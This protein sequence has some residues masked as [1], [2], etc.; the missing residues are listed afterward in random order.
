MKRIIL[1]IALVAFT[2]FASV[3]QEKK[4][5]NSVEELP[6]HAYTFPV[7]QV[8]EMLSNQT[9]L[10]QLMIEIKRDL[11]NDLNAYDIQDHATLRQYYNTLNIIAFLEKDYDQCLVYIDQVR[12][13]S[14][15]KAQQ[16]LSGLF[17]RQLAESMKKNPDADPEM[18]QA[19]VKSQMIKAME[20]M[21]IGIIQSDLEERKGEADLYSEN[22]LKGIVQGQ[23][24]PMVENNK[25]VVPLDVASAIPNIYFFMN[26]YL[27]FKDAL[28]GAYSYILDTYG[29]KVEKQNIWAD[30]NL[31]LSDQDPISPVVVGIWDTG[32]DLDV[33]PEANRWKNKNEIINGK[34]DD[35]NGFV[36]DYYGIAYE[37]KGET[38][39]SILLPD[40]ADQGNMDEM[41]TNMKGLLDLTAN[42]NSDEATAL[43][44]KIAQM[45]AG[46]VD[47]FIQQIGLYSNFAHGTHVGGIAAEGNP[48][49]KILSARISFD[50]R[51]VPFVPD[52]ESAQAWANMFGQ[53]VD[54]FKANGVKVV[55]M[56]WT[57]GLETEFLNPMRINGF[58]SNEEERMAQA[59]KLFEIERAAYIKAVESAPDI[60]FVCG[61]GNSNN[62]VD[63]AMEFP[64][65]L[66]LPNILTV[67]AVDIEGKKTG[68]TT[69]GASVDV[70]ANGYEVESLV[71]GGH[72]LAFSGTSMA[73][74]QVVN[75][76]AK[77]WAVDPDLTVEQ[78]KDLILN[79][80]TESDEHIMLLN[81]AGAYKELIEM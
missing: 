69:E 36:D 5:I 44:K 56:S 18:L 52:E 49:I 51:S 20:G 65:S 55:N 76:A 80:A 78:V 37:M 38:S 27:P 57:V 28:V 7:M 53:V 6:K 11:L 59:K 13:N 15:K 14:D 3:A 43:K 34:D 10:T 79:T 47:G 75:L 63:F 23:L 30:R 73:S 46:D 29:T 31:V 2:A 16:L 35:N 22:V 39:T 77:L 58:G 26:Y 33:F 42:I 60:L 61:A 12:A 4:A 70:Y 17:M 67:G 24:Q 32:V 41:E 48:A 50:Y 81:P 62:D 66:N 19:D 74:P 54:Y 1:F 45:P 40:V 64:A 8:E 21:D 71:P 72:R 25:G 68:F 9:Y